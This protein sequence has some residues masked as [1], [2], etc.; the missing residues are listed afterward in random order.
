MTPSELQKEYLGQVQ[1]SH[2]AISQEDQET[3]DF[4]LKRMASQSLIK[5]EM[6][7]R[8]QRNQNLIDIFLQ[9]HRLAEEGMPPIRF[10][11]AFGMHRRLYAEMMEN[12]P[13]AEIQSVMRTADG[14][15]SAQALSCT[16]QD[17]KENS[18][19]MREIKKVMKDVA[20]AT[21]NGI[22][23]IGYK[24][25]EGESKPVFRRVDPRNF[26]IDETALELHNDDEKSLRARDCTEVILMSLTSFRRYAKSQE[27]WRNIDL[28]YGVNRA[29]TIGA[30]IQYIYYAETVRDGMSA[31]EY[32][33]LAKYCN[34]DEDMIVYVANGIPVYSCKLTEEYENGKLPYVHYKM[35]DR[36]DLPWA[37][38]WVDVVYEILVQNDLLNTFM[39]DQL[40]FVMNKP[41]VVDG[42]LGFN[43]E[44]E[45]IRPGAVLRVNGL[46]A[47][48]DIRS[49]LQILET[50]TIDQNYYNVRNIL[51]DE[52]TMA[53]GDDMR[54]L[55]ANPN[56]LA[57]QTAY[58]Q[59]TLNKLI[60][61]IA[62][63][64]EA[65]TV[66][67]ETRLIIDILSQ[68]YKRSPE[69]P[70]ITVRGYRVKQ[71]ARG[72]RIPNFEKAPNV[73]DSFVLV[74]AIF[75]GKYRIK[76]SGK[77]QKDADNENALKNTLSFL[78]TV[79]PLAQSLPDFA[80][81]FDMYSLVYDIADR[82]GVEI[83]QVFPQVREN[84]I[85][86]AD[87]IVQDI[88]QGRD[89]NLSVDDPFGTSQDLLAI[90]QTP[91]YKNMTVLQKNAVDNA[92]RKLLQTP[93]KQDEAQQAGELQNQVMRTDVSMPSPQA[94]A[95]PA[96]SENN[97][98]ATSQTFK[99]IGA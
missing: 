37:D 49:R 72:K 63:S 55:Y 48:E 87:V 13:E 97:P 34:Q 50:G 85:S 31:G 57:T 28:V 96:T 47:G 38:S 69:K 22:L 98:V 27:G 25:D 80:N 30:L 66:I 91:T 52:L 99:T 40:K 41:M 95:T 81:K 17:A 93:P 15:A 61:N 84:S 90:S 19:Y 7:D 75:D 79:L 60:K 12:R 51:S 14:L 11:T 54:G 83:T 77:T 67:D 5:S 35:Y 76:I 9:T 45:L 53:T 71:S 23:S 8:W 82:L 86:D 44:G 1:R 73:E 20:G 24:I 16:I 29:T 36:N 43:T 21:G 64:N 65:D 94:A 32:V 59:R 10:P 2:K 74:S 70:V 33:Q 68:I 56:Q 26:L 88:L 78:Q 18:N 39:M 4:V 62:I 6:A 92:I 46:R 89:P 58:K 3:R 42:A